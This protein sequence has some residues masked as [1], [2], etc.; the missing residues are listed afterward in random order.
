M[1]YLNAILTKLIGQRDIEIS[2]LM[3]YL[4]NPVAIREHSNIGEEVENKI[5]NIDSL[6]SKIET[7]NELIKQLNPKKPE[8]PESDQ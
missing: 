2:D 1:N 4:N 8:Q 7:I 5:S 6:N 3:V